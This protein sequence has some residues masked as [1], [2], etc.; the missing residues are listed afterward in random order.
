MSQETI[1][2]KIIR[3]EIAAAVVFE[4]EHVLA[5]KDIAPQAPTHILLIPKKALKDIA[6]AQAE[7]KA[8]L[9]ELLFSAAEVARQQGLESDGY[10]VVIN[11]GR[12]GGQTVF[13]LHLHIIGGRALA[14]PPG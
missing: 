10:R 12:D 11:T 4:N 9:G 14:W 8:L 3:G 5:F 7:D 2:S 6:S 13:H 1:F